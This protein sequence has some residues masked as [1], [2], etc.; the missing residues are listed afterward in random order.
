[1]TFA[2]SPKLRTLLWGWAGQPLPDEAVAVLGGLRAGLDGELGAALEPLLTRAE[3]AAT[4]ARVAS[5]LEA[6]VHPEPS[7]EWPAVPWP[8]I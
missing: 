6:G 7:G 2:T 4:R 3:I 8:P 5:L 1:V